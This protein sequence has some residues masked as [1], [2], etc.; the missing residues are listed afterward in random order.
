MAIDK[1]SQRSASLIGHR[2]SIS[3]DYLISVDI[4]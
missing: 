1:R 3:I 2:L 4:D